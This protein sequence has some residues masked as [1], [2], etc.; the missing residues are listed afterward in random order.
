MYAIRSY[1]AGL[2]LFDYDGDGDIDI[3]F[4]NGAPLRG[5]KADVAPGNALYRNDG[6]WKFTDA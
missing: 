3:Y 6:N 5:T 1:Y 4:L 2:A